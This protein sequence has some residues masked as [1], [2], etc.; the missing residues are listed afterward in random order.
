LR[1][2]LRERGVGPVVVKKRGSPIQPE[3]LIH[4]LKLEGDKERIVILTQWSGK[5]IAVICYPSGKFSS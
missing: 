1:A 2:A 5:P 3:D 4:D